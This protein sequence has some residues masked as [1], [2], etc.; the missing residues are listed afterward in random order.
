MAP[1]KKQKNI[2]ALFAQPFTL[3]DS[4]GREWVMRPP[5]KLRGMEQAVVYAGLSHAQQK[6]GKCKACGN[7]DTST[8]EPKTAAAWD[9]LQDRE[10]E[11]VILGRKMYDAMLEA[12]V[13][14]SEMHWMALYTMWYWVLGEATADLLIDTYAQSQSGVNADGTE[15][16][17]ETAKFMD[18]KAPVTPNP[19]MSGPSSE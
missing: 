15:M 17:E 4:E 1:K 19:S 9:A 11:E 12:E 16:D 2:S 18:P 10:L 3:T 5:H 8:M 7:L 13:A 14:A 6:G